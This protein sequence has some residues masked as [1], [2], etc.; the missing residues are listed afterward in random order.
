MNELVVRLGVAL[1][2]VLVGG[3]GIGLA[4]WVLAKANSSPQWRYAVFTLGQLIFPIVF[5]GA[6]ILAEPPLRPGETNAI[7]NPN[8]AKEVQTNELGDP[9]VVAVT[10]EWP[11]REVGQM[12]ASDSRSDAVNDDATS[13]FSRAEWGDSLLNLISAGSPW[14]VGLWMAGSLFFWIRLAFGWAS[15][16]QL[17][18]SST[19]VEDVEWR[20]KL[21]RLTSRL[22]ISRPVALLESQRVSGPITMGW[23]KPVI[24]IPVG[25][26]AKLPADQVE[27]LILHELAH[28][29]R[30]DFL[31]NWLQ[32]ALEAVFFFHPVIWWLGR[33]SRKA[34]EECCD[35][36]V[37]ASGMDRFDYAR[38]LTS[39]QAWQSQQLA[40]AAGGG[41]LKDRILKLLRPESGGWK[42][43]N[44]LGAALVL[45]VL[46]G[47][48]LIPAGVSQLTAADEAQSP[49]QVD[50]AVEGIVVDP[51]GNP[52][53]DAELAL[54]YYGGSF[55]LQTGV[56]A[57]VQSDREGKFAFQEPLE[58]RDK[59]VGSWRDRYWVIAR[60]PDWAV[61]WKV[62]EALPTGTTVREPLRME[63]AE[64][65]DREVTAKTGDGKPVA[66]AQVW[67]AFAGDK[68]SE[69][70]TW[71]DRLVCRKNPGLFEGVTD[72]EGKLLLSNLPKMRLT[73]KAE[74]EGYTHAY[75]TKNV[76]EEDEGLALVLR[77][78]A[79]Y[80]G[81]V[82]DEGGGGLL[83]V[84]VEVKADDSADYWV[85][86]TDA[87]GNFSL[88]SLDGKGDSAWKGG[89]GKGD[90]NLQFRH[91]GYVIPGRRF[92]LD[93]G[94]VKQGEEIQAV[95][96]IPLVAVL[97]ESGTGQP[98]AGAQIT[99]DTGGG[100]EV[101]F[102]DREGT[103]RFAVTPG[104]SHFLNVDSPPEGYFLRDEHG[105]SLNW[106][107]IVFEDQ[108]PIR[109]STGS[110]LGKTHPLESVLRL[111]DGSVAEGGRVWWVPK[112]HGY[113]MYSAK[114]VGEW[115][116]PVAEDGSYAF[117]EVPAEL[118]MYLYAEANDHQYAGYI[119]IAGIEEG[120]AVEIP[121]Q[122][123]KERTVQVV[124]G[125]G[126]PLA[127]KEMRLE[128]KLGS[129]GGNIGG[130]KLK[131]D[132]QGMLKLPG[133]LPDLEYSLEDADDYYAHQRM[134]FWKGDREESLTEPLRVPIDPQITI[135]LR[136][137]QG[138]PLTIAAIP[139][140]Y[141]VSED[142]SRWTNGPVPILETLE[143]GAVIVKRS[144]FALAASG[145]EFHGQVQ[146][147]E[148]LA[149]SA[150]GPFP[151]KGDLVL[152]LTLEDSLGPLPRLGP[153]E[154]P[155]LKPSP[156]GVSGRILDEQGQPIE[157]V[158]VAMGPNDSY[159][160]SMK[161]GPDGTYS[162]EIESPGRFHCLRI[163][164]EGFASRWIPRH[165]VMEPVNIRL[166][167]QT[168]LQGQFQTP[169]G[170]PAGPV[171]VVLVTWRPT[172]EERWR[173][174]LGPFKLYLKTDEEGR[175][176]W[177]VEPGAYRVEAKG[178]EA[179]VMW[180]DQF[181]ISEGAKRS[182]PAKLQPGQALEL[183]LV[184]DSTGEPVEGYSLN[185]HEEYAP[186]HIRGIPGSE[187]TTNDEGVAIWQG[188][189]PGDLQ[190]H[191]YSRLPRGVG[192]QSP[193]VRWWLEEDRQAE[194]PSWFVDGIYSLSVKISE[195]KVTKTVRLQK[196]VRVQG[197]VKFPDGEDLDDEERPSISLAAREA[198]GE[199]GNLGGGRFDLPCNR[200]GHFDAWIPAP[201]RQLQLCAFESVNADRRQFGMAVSKPF[202]ATPGA[203]FEF[204]LQ[205][206]RGGGVKG[207]IEK[208]DGSGFALP[209]SVHID[210]Q[211]GLR[212]PSGLLWLRLG[213]DGS[214]H[215]PAV[216]PG[217]YRI[218][219]RGDSGGEF[220][221]LDP[222]A[223][224][225]KIVDGETIDLGTLKVLN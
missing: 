203:S 201:D 112:K 74:R 185:F 194:T 139:D 53:A 73:L 108:G 77:P 25:M 170:T 167:N 26:L 159:D 188:L 28:I 2:T 31:V 45:A 35:E 181:T 131:T 9:E 210:R 68:G 176:D 123:T 1:V 195:E 93:S 100:R 133:L 33:E 72:E 165:L 27:A 38:T 151:G 99:C 105:G 18:G 92:Q 21:D 220:L 98:V 150:E 8:A 94:E 174:K 190:I 111:P 113:I 50:P 163:E 192:E 83:G 57:R 135:R 214:F 180:Q 141:A 169:E 97:R 127:G 152:N 134:V 76:V 89:G 193:Y 130:K 62:V 78:A 204:D 144:H 198:S 11:P 79:S 125:S 138:M 67:I 65:V 225:V 34:R 51:E 19:K 218:N 39:L 187:R 126:K 222:K 215:F 42:P 40:Q 48:L 49:R 43:A 71:R 158:T 175:Y 44:P 124:D 224:T 116:A 41:S 103:V 107:G 153:S 179:L 166:S 60:H 183:R 208:P 70:S 122:E 63:L 161:T 172:T 199:G 47:V 95:K 88:T 209:P 173:R 10:E 7:S 197:T 80:S 149:G 140:F 211:D 164:K 221:R 189:V 117:D 196:G 137:S 58:F 157:G 3:A 14:L 81:R 30:L 217:L 115:S 154:D 36:M 145:G 202:E 22:G 56:A 12:A 205:L 132:A 64:G 212:E 37:V 171:D 29:R 219:V 184:D 55:S 142:G 207:R 160:P 168:R 87:E 102:T 6:V 16:S 186:A 91:P 213:K 128:P 54:Y 200:D 109:L 114:T 136:D 156:T 148:G 24:L 177:P 15:L 5:L 46:C 104:E 84:V 17:R 90:F 147:A 146:T 129:R 206:V 69:C 162:L 85:T 101:A 86:E 178:P 61:G 66:G 121:L 4:A 191:S 216:A 143:D 82:V 13:T 110:R 59:E 20:A 155:A 32:A 182:L 75:R 96:G 119:E 23:L 52:L 118:K 106:Q 120:K 223:A